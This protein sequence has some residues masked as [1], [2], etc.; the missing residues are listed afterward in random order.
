[1]SS[2]KNSRHKYD[3]FLSYHQKDKAMATDMLNYLLANDVKV[4]SEYDAY[5]Q[6]IKENGIDV[7]KTMIVCASKAYSGSKSC[8]VELGYG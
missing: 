8:C 3:A 5:N 4:W 7:S 6:H 1:M 2:E